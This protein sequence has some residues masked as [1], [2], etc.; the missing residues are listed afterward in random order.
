MNFPFPDL[1]E[2]IK[3]YN[4]SLQTIQSEAIF[5]R[6]IELQK[7]KLSL[8]DELIS[9]VILLKEE[10]IIEQ[11][12]DK[13][14]F[15]LCLQFA[16]EAMKNELH[17]IIALKEDEAAKA[18]DYLIDA[19]NLVWLSIRNN[20]FKGEYL[21]GYAQ[22]LHLYEIL[23]FPQTKLASR[24]CIVGKTEC[25]ICNQPYGD[26]EHIKGHFYMGKLCNEIIQELISLEEI[27]LVDNPADKKCRIISYSENGKSFDV[28]TH[29]ELKN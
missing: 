4:S 3:K 22:R 25:S 17:L 27:S 28:L 23:L 7:E 1:N 8:V 21:T 26:C 2:F 15:L 9:E 18:W 12:E 14:N 19:Q 11:I 16:C 5:V 6:G 29:R 13:A 24:G 20:P 10:A